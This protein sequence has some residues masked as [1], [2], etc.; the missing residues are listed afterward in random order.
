MS[1]R[2]ASIP[3]TIIVVAVFGGT[4]G[5]VA[6]PQG[7]GLRAQ[8][9][10]LPQTYSFTTVMRFP[11]YP[12]PLNIRLYRD[13]PKEVVDT[14]GP[15][16]Q[17][18]ATGFHNLQLYDFQAHKMYTQDLLEASHPCSVQKYAD[19]PAQS[20]WDP[21]AGSAQMLADF[22]KQ[23]PKTVGSE[24]INGLAAKVMEAPDPDTHGKVKAWVLEKYGIVVKVVLIPPSGTPVFKRLC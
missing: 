24:T 9:S 15:P 21:I 6:D 7:T 22:A 19:S 11:L 4:L 17:G 14:T 18:K 20:W 23:N 8:S 3:T 2:R 5:F 16:V 13:G 10:N 12:A 1:R